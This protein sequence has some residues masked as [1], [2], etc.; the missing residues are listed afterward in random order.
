LILDFR[1]S[2]FDSVINQKSRV[3]NILSLFILL[4]LLTGCGE[5]EAKIRVGVSISGIAHPDSRL[6]KQAI[7]ENAGKYGARIVNDT[8]GLTELLTKG[9]RV[10]IL[11]R[12]DLKELESSIQRTH[13]EGI[14]VVVLDSPPPENLHVEAYI[15]VNQFNAGKMAADYVVKELDGKGNVIILEGPRD[16]EASRQITLGMYSLLEQHGSIRIVA[17]KRHPNWSERLAA[18]T[19]RF[20]LNRYAE[21]VQGILAC[22]SQLAVGALP[23]VMARR[24]TGNI[25]TVGIGADMAACKAI[26]AGTHDVE[27]DREPYGRGSEALALAVAVAKGEDFGYDEEI[28]E[29]PKIKVKFGP[30][31]LITKENVS[32]MELAWPQLMDEH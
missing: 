26:I 2:I 27:V 10:L 20:T 11:S 5:D 15:R 32:V 21:N 14:P 29:A 18:D 6:I 25:T 23:A 4:L 16:D 12:S 9:I 24:L 22:S 3:G 19:V 1:F 17:S 13:H 28:G 8:E 7:E 31:R 30:L